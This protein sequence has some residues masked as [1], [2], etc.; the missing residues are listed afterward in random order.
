MGSLQFI[1][2]NRSENT[3]RRCWRVMLV[4][5][6]GLDVEKDFFVEC[7]RSDSFF[8]YIICWE[9]VRLPS[10]LSFY[11]ALPYLKA[12]GQPVPCSVG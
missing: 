11:S 3:S 2:D 8:I 4:V 10:V 5:H 12:K 7:F 1:I 9:D 6:E